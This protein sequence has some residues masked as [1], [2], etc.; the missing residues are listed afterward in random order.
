MPDDYDTQMAL[1]RQLE[2]VHGRIDDTVAK[3]VG[4]KEGLTADGLEGVPAWALAEGKGDLFKLCVRLEVALADSA[5]WSGKLCERLKQ[6]AEGEPQGFP[7]W[8]PVGGD[9]GPGRPDPGAA[10][11]H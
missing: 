9:Q 6:L 1:R 10:P 3:L 7:G 2:V 5:E 11:P 8:P 4:A